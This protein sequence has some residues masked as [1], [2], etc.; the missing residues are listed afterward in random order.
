MCVVLCCVVCVV[1]H[2]SSA[3]VVMRRSCETRSQFP[4]VFKRG[5]KPDGLYESFHFNIL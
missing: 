3:R 4:H 2:L 1:V 5:L